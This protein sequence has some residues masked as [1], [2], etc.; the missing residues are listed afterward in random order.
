[1]LRQDVSAPLSISDI[2]TQYLSV[3]A[4]NLSEVRLGSPDS[5]EERGAWEVW[6]YPVVVEKYTESKRAANVRVEN[7][8][9]LKLP[10]MNRSYFALS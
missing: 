3:Y 4:F 10:Y 7:S 1:M 6:N 2:E 8:G 5:K 9:Q